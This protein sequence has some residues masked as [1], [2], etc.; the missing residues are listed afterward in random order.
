MFT[1]CFSPFSGALPLPCP[2]SQALPPLFIMAAREMVGNMESLVSALSSVVSLWAGN[3]IFPAST[4]LNQKRGSQAVWAVAPPG[5]CACSTCV[6]FNFLLPEDHIKYY[7][8]SLR[9]LFEFVFPLRF[10][11]TINYVFSE[12]NLSHQISK[13]LN[14]SRILHISRC[15]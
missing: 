7:A 5:A 2:V 4:F 13:L 6:A 12:R 8:Q 9:T 11:E 15:K 14:K 1:R 10:F 3:W